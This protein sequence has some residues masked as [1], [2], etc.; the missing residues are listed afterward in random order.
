MTFQEAQDKVQN[1]SQKPNNEELL[2]LYALF[3]Q[4]SIGD[5]N[6]D[7]PANPFDFKATAKQNAWRDVSG[8]DPADAET[9][10]IAKVEELVSKYGSA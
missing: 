2:K 5:C 10:Y 8:L 4:A 7:P 6:E 1:L 3:K 9:Q